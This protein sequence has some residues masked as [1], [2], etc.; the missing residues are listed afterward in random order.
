MKNEKT[1]K[2][3]F[4]GRI[5]KEDWKYKYFCI[6]VEN[7]AFC[8]I[9]NEKI[10]VLKEYNLKRH[11]DTKHVSNYTNYS[12]KMKKD[13]FNKLYLNMQSKKKFMN[14][15]FI[16][17]KDITLASYKVAYNLAKKGKPFTDCDTIK[18]CIL[19]V[20]EILIPDKLKILETL[21][22]NRCTIK[23]RTEY[24][25]ENIIKQLLYKIKE[26][27]SFSIS[28]DESTDITDTAQLLIFIRGCDKNFNLTQELLACRSMH[29]TTTGKD[30][31][32]EI[33]N[34]FIEFKMDW[35]KLESVTMDGGK[36]MAGIYNGV[37]GCI[38]KKFSELKKIPPV[39]FHCIIHQ[40]SLCLKHFDM[41]DILKPI[42]KAINFIRSRSLNHRQFQA[43][44]KELEAEFKDIIYYTA[45]R[46]LSCGLILKR[47]YILR[48]EICEFLS[49]KNYEDVLYFDDKFF[50]KLAFYTDLTNHIN[51]LNISLQGKENLICDYY[52]YIENFITKLRLFK[53]QICQHNF[54]HMPFCAKLNFKTNE[55]SEFL[56][57]C[58]TKINE[59]ENAF[60][61][62]FKDVKHEEIMLKV[63][64]NPFL[65]DVEDAPVDL[66]MD[67]IALK[68][69]TCA[70]FIY[71]K[72]NLI[73]FYA[74]LDQN[75][76]NSMKQF[77]IKKITIFGTTYLCEQT[78]SRLKFL[79]SKYRSTL[80]DE[81]LNKLLVINTSDIVPD[82]EE[83][84]KKHSQFHQSH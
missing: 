7:N 61:N 39:F 17:N 50:Q 6:K 4:E 47:F 46:W 44:L 5:F 41:Q 2:I 1:R 63:L 24:I 71:Q 12:D 73:N 37:V 54:V 43:F 49:M 36:N 59:L 33:E 15:T 30:I 70:Q 18:N 13:H 56:N 21:P 82:Y 23:R 67:L 76:Y 84:L 79:K 65:V 60:N 52:I 53:T 22:L 34:V 19:D 35:N 11:F 29:N 25:G 74:G 8:L 83:I 42:I 66:Q 69:D 45:V 28:L 58:N 72:E 3:D 62:R 81:M 51:L 14:N 75:K 31:F 64:K 10:S 38:R 68:N 40:Q 26:M 16:N 20:A 27:E 77:V 9:C 55:F 78:F 32:S 80:T 57:F 48:K